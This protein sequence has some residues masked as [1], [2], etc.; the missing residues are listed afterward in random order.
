[1]KNSIQSSILIYR[2]M[3]QLLE[4]VRSLDL[5]QTKAVMATQEQFASLQKEAEE[6]DGIINAHLARGQETEILLPLLQERHNVIKEV[7]ETN[8]RVAPRLITMMAVVQ[9]E[10]YE[11]R[12]GR[13]AVAGYA[14]GSRTASRRFKAQG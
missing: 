10:L 8:R 5:D 4:G 3:Q 7:A 1:M 13:R 12:T 11:I 14:R 2:R 6:I 9:A